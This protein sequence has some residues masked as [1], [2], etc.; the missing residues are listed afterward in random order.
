[1]MAEMRANARANDRANEESQRRQQ[2]AYDARQRSSSNS[3]G[4]S[5]SSASTGASYAPYQAA[6]EGP[7]SVVATYSFTIHKQESESQTVARIEREARSGQMQ[8]QFNLGRIY[9]TG[10]GVGRSDAKAREWFGAA[11]D[12]GHPAAET[13]YGLM[14]FHGQGGASDRE[15]GLSYLKKA[16][17]HGDI[18]G[19][20]VY[21]ALALKPLI[22]PQPELVG[23]LVKAADAGDLVAQN[24]L[25]R[26]VYYLGAGAPYDDVKALK[27]LRMAA[28]QHD[29][30]SMN[31]LGERYLSGEGVLK[32]EARGLSLLKASADAGFPDAQAQYGFMQVKGLY[33]VHQD[34]TAGASALRTADQS[35]SPLAAFYLGTMN[36]FGTGMPKDPVT[37]DA[38][39]KRAADGGNRDA[40]ARYGLNLVRG[41]GV[42]QD[43][44]KGTQLIQASADVGSDLGEE[45]LARLYF[46]GVGVPKDRQKSAQ[47]FRKAAA[48]G[49]EAAAHALQTEP[50]FK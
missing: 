9:Y 33:G 24:A 20:A 25:G 38:F 23:Y 45:F 12:Q 47:W 29:P 18:H 36:E 5:S 7:H 10:Y 2:A 49:N 32:D 16:A 27:Y 46:D 4:G 42:A 3:G 41:L 11:A 13:Q 28:E 21:G 1:M 8:S 34:T 6:P 48:H 22:D 43:I 50:D 31:D 19:Q 40:K 30:S 17:E 35:G 37:A 15:R 14:L 44:A 26:V 39:Y